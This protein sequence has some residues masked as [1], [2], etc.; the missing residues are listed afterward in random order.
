M[1]PCIPKIA[2]FYGCGKKKFSLGKHDIIPFGNIKY[3]PVVTVFKRL[4]VFFSCFISSPNEKILSVS[5]AQSHA[6]FFGSS[7]QKIII[8]QYLR[9]T[10]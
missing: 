8:L 6:T 4:T 7:V 1:D 10:S 2:A 3:I 5:A 9:K